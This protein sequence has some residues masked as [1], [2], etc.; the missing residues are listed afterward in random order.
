ML[1]EDRR[2]LTL[3]AEAGNRL[4][5][6]AAR[7]GPELGPTARRTVSAP[8]P[9]SGLGVA[10]GASVQSTKRLPAVARGAVI[11]TSDPDGTP[12]G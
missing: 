11:L 6:L 5:E 8:L 10:H 7:S 1:S 3:G 2:V 4:P 9:L 12:R